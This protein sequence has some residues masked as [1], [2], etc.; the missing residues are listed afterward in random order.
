MPENSKF[1]WGYSKGGLQYVINSK[2]R[3]SMGQME[4]IPFKQQQSANNFAKEHGGD[5]VSYADIP[6]NYILGNTH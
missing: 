4:V 3:G 6:K 2:Q 1:A 5:I